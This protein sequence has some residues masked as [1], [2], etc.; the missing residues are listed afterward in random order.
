MQDIAG[1]RAVAPKME[2]VRRI[3]EDYQS[4]P[5]R[6]G[7]IKKIHDYITQ[8]KDSGYRSVH[9]VLHYKGESPS[10][11]DGLRVELQ[12]RTD[13]QHLWGS[14]VEITGMWTGQRVKYDE[15]D[16]NWIE[17]FALAGELIARREGTQK[18]AKY[19]QISEDQ[20]R[21]N[22]IEAEQKVDALN[23]MRSRAESMLEVEYE[24]A[25]TAHPLGSFALLNLDPTLERLTIAPYDKDAQEEALLAYAHAEQQATFLDLPIAPVLVSVNSP[26]QLQ[27]AY[28]SFF[29]DITPFIDL[30]LNLLGSSAG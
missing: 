23:V 26:K 18:C 3:V 15:G 6:V 19:A 8:P 29:Q 14:A 30:L 17:V 9:L 24:H 13:A 5:P 21:I 27:T 22:L 4:N 25:M 11:Y 28:R 16:P 20:V 1:V 2:D 7:H 12:V 10:T